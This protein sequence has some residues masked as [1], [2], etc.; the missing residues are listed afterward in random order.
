MLTNDSGYFS[1]FDASNVEILVKTLNGCG[2]NSR[3]WVFG[4]G[5]TD[6]EVTLRVTD[7]YSGVVKTYDNS[8]GTAF[9][10]IQDTSAFATC[11]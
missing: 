9:Q 5:L 3:Y 1:F 2:L 4:A 8:R 11:P 10:P 6:V 7:T